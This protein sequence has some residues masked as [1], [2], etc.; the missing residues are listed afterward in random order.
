MCPHC[1]KPLIVL[2]L[3]GVEVDYCTTCHGVWL[4]AGELEFIAELAG[5][6]HGR[7]HAALAAAGSG[8]NGKRRC[9]RC[10]R[11]L[12]RIRIA[13]VAGSSGEDVELDQ[14]P[15]RHGLWLDA[16][17]LA[18]VVREFGTTAD[19]ALSDFFGDLLRPHSAARDAASA[20]PR[21]D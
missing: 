4:D 18:T 7:L 3:R 15:A 16:G 6:P 8:S 17:E 19:A 10:R 1:R 9:P 12:R 11:K 5:A 20:A 13:A 14:C 21:E 2:E